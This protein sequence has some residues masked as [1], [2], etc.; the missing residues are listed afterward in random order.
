MLEENGLAAI[1]KHVMAVTSGKNR[2]GMDD[3]AKKKTDSPKVRVPRQKTD[4]SKPSS[5]TES[6]TPHCRR[7]YTATIL[8]EMGIDT[9]HLPKDSKLIN[10]KDKV[11]DKDTWYIQ[12][13]FYTPAKVTCREYKIGRFNGPNSAPMYFKFPVRILLSNVIMPKLVN[14]QY[15]VR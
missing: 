3:S 13:F 15:S 11:T 7:V 2:N 8:E 1:V 9:S 12:P 10:W 4:K 5:D 14:H 6:N